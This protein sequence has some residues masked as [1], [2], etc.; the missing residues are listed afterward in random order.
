MSPIR[1]LYVDDEEELLELG[2]LYLELNGDLFIVL[3]SS[4]KSALVKLASDHFDAVVADYMMPEM[5]GIDLLKAI[6]SKSQIPFILFTGKG[7]EEV[8]IEAL[9]SGA[10][11]YLH[12][13]GDPKAQFA[14][15][16]HKINE[17]VQ[18]R[19]TEQALLES[20]TN[21]HKIFNNSNDAIFILDTDG[22]FLDV[23]DVACME[24]GYS[25]DELLGLS[26]E[27]ITKPEFVS[28]IDEHVKQT[29]EKGSLMFETMHLTKDGTA[30]PV[31]LSARFVIYNGKRAILAI[32]RN[33]SE[34]KLAEE[35][36]KENEQS[37]RLIAE[38]TKDVIW[39]LDLRTQRFTYIS[40]SIQSLRGLSVEEAMKESL[41][42]AIDP[43][44]YA[45]ITREL[46]ERINGFKGG[47]R[48]LRDQTAMF[49][50]RRKDGSW[51]TV[52]V[53][54]TLLINDRGEVTE[55]LGVSRD[56]TER[57]QAE[58]IQSA[59]YR[60]SR[61]ASSAMSLNELYLSIHEILQELMPAKN[62]FISLYDPVRDELSYPYFIDEF[63]PSPEPQRPGKGLTA[64]VLSTGKPLLA[65]PEVFDELVAK[66]EVDLTGAPSVDWLGV[67]L[68][69]ADQTIGVMATQSYT[70]GVR[71]SESDRQIM[72]FISDQVAMAIERKEVEH[73]QLEAQ[74]ALKAANKKLNLLSSI[75]RHDILN[76]VAALEG[77]I[78]L[79]KMHLDEP[80]KMREFL[81]RERKAAKTIE[82]QISFTKDYQDM[83]MC[84]PAW[85]NLEVLV[86]RAAAQLHL[87]KVWI[88]IDTG[89]LEI[90]ADSLLEKAIYN[91]IDNSLRHGGPNL[92]IITLT[93]KPGD[94]DLS[95][96]YEDNGIGISDAD[97]EN[98]F[99]Y[100]HGKH[101][102]LGL[103]LSR[104]ILSITG[105][106]I[107][108]S[109]LLGRGARF[110][111]SVPEG[112]YRGLRAA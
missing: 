80:A 74:E 77:Y 36:L 67:P 60:I 38:N 63:D 46:P 88:K 26:P 33:I 50:Q 9:N 6:R 89:R 106:S 53:V 84:A 15:L 57:R 58:A 23:N 51:V 21:F 32:A 55:I 90:Y 62:F 101:T 97:R 100:G 71:L 102:G 85:Q 47:D 48:T 42:D 94:T 87:S 12:K 56:A 4:A 52:E 22:R 75:T 99:H 13:G 37:F 20:E 104:E 30:I 43:D 31:E 16:K 44:S 19:R 3:A 68:R 81:E 5:N 27:S 96:T 1:V 7:R 93:A 78:D 35:R 79:S 49:N 107:I 82:R 34:R 86:R 54:T 28:E 95:L 17:A 76:Q 109:S 92:T 25:R 83:G 69:I 111:I 18:K 11:F 59:L 110:E 103:F 91:I 10:D 105:M 24:L 108:E 98:L 61:A 45:M 64:Y 112:A 14:E 70:E 39:K 65:P 73:A 29:L 40:P 41:S 2:K 8:V 66:G 72:E